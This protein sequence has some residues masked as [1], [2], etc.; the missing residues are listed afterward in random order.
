MTDFEPWEVR[1]L[2]R[3]AERELRRMASQH[4][5]KKAEERAWDRMESDGWCFATPREPVKPDWVSDEKWADPLYRMRVNAGASLNID[6][7]LYDRY[8]RYVKEE[9]DAILEEIKQGADREVVERW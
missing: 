6:P 3:V 1:M 5:I 2:K 7:Q 8:Q 9:A 4:C